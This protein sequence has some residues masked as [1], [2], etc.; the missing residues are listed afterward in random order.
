MKD[1]KGVSGPPRGCVLL[2]KAQK[3]VFETYNPR[4][5]SW[6]G[7]II[8]TVF[9]NSA[10]FPPPFTMLFLITK[11]GLLIVLMMGHGSLPKRCRAKYQRLVMISGDYHVNYSASFWWGLKFLLK[12]TMF[13]GREGF[14]QKIKC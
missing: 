5:K 11:S 9:Y 7:W 14:D 2:L 6:N 4:Q 8:F 13:Y 3:R 10:P 1:P 12:T